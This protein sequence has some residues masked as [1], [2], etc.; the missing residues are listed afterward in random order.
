[1]MISLLGTIRGWSLLVPRDCPLKSYKLA[2]FVVGKLDKVLC[3]YVSLMF[4]TGVVD[5]CGG[6]AGAA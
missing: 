6:Y 4:V 1:M 3:I 5:G 2:L